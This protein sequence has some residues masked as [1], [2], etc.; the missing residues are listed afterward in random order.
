MLP[1]ENAALGMR[2]C[3]VYAECSKACSSDPEHVGGH[4]GSKDCVHG[5][6][7]LL[8]GV[9]RGGNGQQA[10]GG[11]PQGFQALP[12][13]CTAPPL[14][15]DEAQRPRQRPCQCWSTPHICMQQHLS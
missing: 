5:G 13:L 3:T 9:L 4:L 12:L 8:G 10:R 11:P 2:A 1:D 15:P 6:D 7:V 14:P